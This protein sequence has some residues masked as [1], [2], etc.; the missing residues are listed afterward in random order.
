LAQ[1]YAAAFSDPHTWTVLPADAPLVQGAV[2]LQQSEPELPLN[3]A[4]ELATAITAGAAVL[5]SDNPLLAHTEQHPV[6]S[7]LRR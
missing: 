5:V 1:R 2:R 3:A 6:L 7:A 4:I